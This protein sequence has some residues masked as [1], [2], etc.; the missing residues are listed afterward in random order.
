MK[1][2]IFIIL[3]ST[4]ALVA[5]FAFSPVHQAQNLKRITM[6]VAYVQDSAPIQINSATHATDFLFSKAEIKNVSDHAVR[7]VTF[8]VFLHAVPPSAQTSMLVST[9]E[10]PTHLKPGETRT[11][12][13]LDLTFDQAQE[14]AAQLKSNP[15]VAEFGILAVKMD[16][17]GIWSSDA[18][19]NGGFGKTS[20]GGQSSV[21]S[22][23]PLQARSDL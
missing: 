9:R 13:V 4:L 23:N 19:N 18:Q 2:R 20:A 10:I 11:V 21:R 3:G 15:I 7:S 14:K 5:L 12:D 1:S 17:G 16:D 22:S 6:E 8:G